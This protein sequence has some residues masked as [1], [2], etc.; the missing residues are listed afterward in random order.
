MLAYVS[1]HNPKIGTVIT[2]DFIVQSTT[3]NEKKYILRKH[4]SKITIQKSQQKS[5]EQ[6][7]KLG[8][9]PNWIKENPAPEL[10][11]NKLEEFD[12]FLMAV[13]MTICLPVMAMLISKSILALIFLCL[14]MLSFI[15]FITF[16]RSSKQ[17]KHKIDFKNWQTESKKFE[18]EKKRTSN[19]STI[20]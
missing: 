10:K 9:D 19:S 13:I 12:T 16:N 15:M 4:I 5:Y 18:I 11:L 1:T 8:V 14:I 2:K 6:V 3:E 7:L 20:S 17:K